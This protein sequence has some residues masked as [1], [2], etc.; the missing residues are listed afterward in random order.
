MAQQIICIKTLLNYQYIAEWKT[1][2]Q[3]TVEK[4]GG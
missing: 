4:Q 1:P 3:S 2:F